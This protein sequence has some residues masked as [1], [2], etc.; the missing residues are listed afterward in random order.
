MCSEIGDGLHSA[1]TYDDNGEYYFINGNNLVNGHI[2]IN[3]VE[4]KRV[5]S[6]TFISNDK[7]LDKN[8]YPTFN[9]WNNWKFGLLCRWKGHVRQKCGI[10]ESGR[11][12][13]RISLYVIANRDD[14]E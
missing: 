4:T 2:E 6:S 13:K 5:S 12:K 14:I 10:F 7:G 1:P 11:Y 9:K 3:E 8:N